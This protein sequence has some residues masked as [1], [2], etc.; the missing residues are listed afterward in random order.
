MRIDPTKPQAT[1]QAARVGRAFPSAPAA[2]VGTPALQ[3]R[4]ACQDLEAV[5]LRHL[6]EKMRETLPKGGLLGQTRDEQLFR[7]LLD[8]ALADE[9]AESGSLGLGRMLYDQLSRAV[10]EHNGRLKPDEASAEDASG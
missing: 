2:G 10:L 3:L 6:L 7:S 5:F 4:R 8:S 9:M 1:A